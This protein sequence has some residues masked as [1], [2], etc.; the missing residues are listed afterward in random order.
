VGAAP[1]A[2]ALGARSGR[3]F[4]IDTASQQVRVFEGGSGAPLA[5][6]GRA[7]GYS[8]GNTTV[9]ADRLWLLPT[10]RGGFVG[11]DDDAREGLWVN[12]F[13]NRRILHL[14][15]ASGAELPGS[16]AYLPVFYRSAVHPLQP[17]RAF[18][19]FLEFSVDYAP[20]PPAWRLVR[21]WGAGLPA[22]GVA[23]D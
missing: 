21:N 9:G 15:P 4:V 11:V 19:N 6:V 10:P 3:L 20:S 7:G 14:D 1:G 18:A 16:I 13:G 12:D 5:P 22:G 17:A 23:L 8:D 2:L